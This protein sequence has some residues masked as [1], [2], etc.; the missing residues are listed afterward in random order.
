MEPWRQLL[1]DSADYIEKNGLA[2]VD[3]EGPGNAKCSIY[4]IY[5]VAGNHLP[6]DVEGTALR[7][8]VDTPP[9]ERRLDPQRYTDRLAQSTR[10]PEWPDRQMTCRRWNAG[11]LCHQRD[12]LVQRCHLAASEDESPIG[13]CWMLAT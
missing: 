6:G 7:K 4:T 3:A 9:I 10:H 2:Q 12:Q 11:D 13:R 5:K 8:E 1:L